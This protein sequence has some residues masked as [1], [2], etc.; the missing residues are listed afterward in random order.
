M[1]LRDFQPRV[2]RSRSC[3]LEGDSDEELVG[4]N[5][6]RERHHEEVAGRRDAAPSAAHQLELGTQHDGDG[7][8]LGGRIGVGEA[9]SNRS[10]VADRNVTDG[11]RRLGSERTGG[12]DRRIAFEHALAHHRPESNAPAVGLHAVKTLHTIH[13]D[14]DSRDG[15]PEIQ[16]R[17]EALAAR[18]HLRVAPV[19]GEKVACLLDRL[20]GAV[21][22]A[23]RLQPSVPMDR[24]ASSWKGRTRSLPTSRILSIES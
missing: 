24:T 14:D 16:E 8:Q 4:G 10:P 13:V 20:G 12:T 15:E 21:V 6:R 18:E 1:T 11:E 22:E 19:P 9:P 2:A 3:S 23:G 7:R 17:P 5:G